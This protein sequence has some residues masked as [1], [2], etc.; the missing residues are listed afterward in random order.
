M[1]EPED[2]IRR[3]LDS[4]RVIALV[5][6]SPDPSRDSHGVMRFLLAHG[7]RVI[8]VNPNNAGGEILGRKVVARLSDIDEPV[9]M[10]DVFRNSQ[11]AAGVT[12]EAIAIGARAVWMQIG[13]INE[14]AAAKARAASLDVVMDRCPRVEMP[15]LGISG[16]AG[17]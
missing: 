13:V 9:D 12:D 8:P 14:A 15:R 3:I 16:P 1:D 10:V 2:T 6:A 5:G 4:A 17:G 11:A 7:Y